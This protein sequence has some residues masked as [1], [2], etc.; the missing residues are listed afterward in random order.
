MEPT[1]ELID[2]YTTGCVYMAAESW[3]GLYQREPSILSRADERANII[4]SAEECFTVGGLDWVARFWDVTGDLYNHGYWA[5][6]ERIESLCLLTAQAQR[7]R[8]RE[9]M[10]H[11]EL[12]F[13]GIQRGDYARAEKEVQAALTLFISLDDLY[14][15]LI[16]E[17]YL[18]TIS[19]ARGEY[20]LARQQFGALL[21]AVRGQLRHATQDAARLER[22]ER[23]VHEGLGI[24][25]RELGDFE[26]AERELE[27]GNL[28]A[29]A[30]TDAIVH[31]NLAKLR[32]KQNR[33]V[34]AA[35]LSN[36]CL[37]SCRE[38]DLPDIAALALENLAEIAAA[39]GDKASAST[40]AREAWK[41]YRH[42]GIRDGA[43]RVVTFISNLHPQQTT[44]DSTPE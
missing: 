43:D 11:N 26:G 28:G 31:L 8:E 14:G 36:A 44:L 15:V 37:N 18:A 33:L 40:Y 23:F 17:R 35:E 5:E 42:L 27:L 4:Y 7:D 13:L 41:I 38:L 22:Q 10:I 25:L 32:R 19:L 1:N 2:F 29:D 34:Q 20:A 21:E 30:K 6:Y 9:A 24:A 16:S 12:G 39:D 3:L